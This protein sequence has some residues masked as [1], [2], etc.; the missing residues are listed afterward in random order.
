M[1]S[2][3]VNAFTISEQD[4]LEIADDLTQITTQVVYDA[5]P[6]A[7]WKIVALGPKGEKVICPK[8]C[9]GGISSQPA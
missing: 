6:P 7:G 4:M 9:G 5:E 8:P 2:L 3:A 1:A